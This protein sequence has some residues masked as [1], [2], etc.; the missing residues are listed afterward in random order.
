VDLDAH[1]EETA[2]LPGGPS[3]V[4]NSL[5]RL[6]IKVGDVL[7]GH[8]E[9]IHNVGD[10]VLG[11]GDLSCPVSDRKM[12]IRASPAAQRSSLSIELDRQ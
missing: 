9:G 11:L 7:A 6:E 4:D 1:A 10:A 12:P 5:G 8:S 2:S 3:Q